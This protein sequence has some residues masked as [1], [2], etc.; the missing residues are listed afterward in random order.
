MSSKRSG[1]IGRLSG[2]TIRMPAEAAI[3]DLAP[4]SAS[5]KADATP[6]TD[7]VLGIELLRRHAAVIDYPHKALYLRPV[8]QK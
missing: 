4:S 3:P 5:R 8:E 7:G 2:G 1:Q 6:A